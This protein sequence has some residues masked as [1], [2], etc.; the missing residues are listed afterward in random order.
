[1]PRTGEVRARCCGSEEK[2]SAHSAQGG[3]HG[4]HLC[5]SRAETEETLEGWV[6]LAEVGW[7]G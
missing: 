3:V 1:M 4:T 6:G 7:V 5:S 2:R